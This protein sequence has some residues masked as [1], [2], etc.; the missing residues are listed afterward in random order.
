M[1]KLL[2]LSFL[3]KSADVALLVLRLAFGLSLLVLHGWGKL[4]R[5]SELS[6]KFPDPLGLG[7]SA[8]LACAIL[9]E[10]VGSALVVLGL[11]T[12]LGAL[13]CAFTMGVAFFMV[14]QLKL[15]GPGNG[16]DALVFLAAFVA[17]FVAG[18]GRY[19]VDAKIGG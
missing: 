5:F 15:K 4:Q 8:S 1:K 10:V 18:G 6:E 14:H 9:A 11:F 13:V 12:R 7:H 16:E 19:S 17:L 2:H 3:P